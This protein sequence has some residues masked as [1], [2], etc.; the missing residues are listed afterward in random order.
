VPS[1]RRRRRFL[2]GPERLL[3]GLGLTVGLA[4]VLCYPPYG[5][6]AD[7]GTHFARALEMAHDRI[8]PGEVDGRIASPIPSSYGD[9][10]DAVVDSIFNGPAPFSGDLRDRLLESR[11]D[12]DDTFVVETQP[13]MAATP[14]AYA[15]AAAAMVLPDRLGWAGL[16]VLWAGRLGNLLVYLAVVLVAVRVATAFRWSIVIAALFPMN[17]GIA[18]SVT[19]DALTIAALLLVVAAWTRVWRPGG[20]ASSSE[21]LVVADESARTRAAVLANLGASIADG[22]TAP[23]GTAPPEPVTDPGGPTPAEQDRTSTVDR[24]GRWVRTPVGTGVMVLGAG[25][26]LVATKPPYFLVLA[27]FPALLVVRWADRSV[28]AAALAAVV[29]LV[30]GGLFTTLTSSGS[31]KAVTTTLKGDIVY[32]PDVQQ[33]RLFADPL[34]FLGRVLADWF[35]NINATVQRWIR[36]VGYVETILPAWVSWTV[37]VLLIL[38]AM[39]LDRGDLLGLRR[40]SRVIWLAAAPALTLVLYASSYIYFDDTVDGDRMGLQIPRYVAPFF[41][42]TVMGW[43][44]RLLVRLPLRRPWADRIPT[45]VPVVAVVAIEVVVI[46]AGI[47]TWNFVRW[48]YTG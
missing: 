20:P 25:L 35:G 26:L 24:L 44:P 5:A 13:T 45:W 37:L 40:F 2:R 27:A 21:A 39:V 32:Q 33:E 46:V 47:R 14:L 42:I 9:D 48:S 36:Y 6:G 11:P 31:Y 34:G 10:Q 4:F 15:P 23:S 30:A 19:P 18:A 28:R 43:A 17:L 1:T 16:W 41:A 8:T 38:A 22:D 29:A 12:W 3:L 7:E